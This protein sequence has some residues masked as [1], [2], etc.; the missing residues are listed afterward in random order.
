ML[1]KSRTLD[2]SWR[3]ISQWPNMLS[4]ARLLMTPVI[5]V[6]MLK[7]SWRL[8]FYCFVIACITDALDGF[9]ARLLHSKTVLGTILDPLA[10]KMLLLTLFIIM[11][12]MGQVSP[13]LF[14][15]VIARDLLIVIG[16][17]SLYWWRHN[18]IMEPLLIGKLTT[19]VQMLF[20]TYTLYGLAF[21]TSLKPIHHDVIALVVLGVTSISGVA[22]LISGV[23]NFSNRIS[24]QDITHRKM[25]GML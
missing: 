11:V 23:L 1:T 14:M 5:A 7:G 18:L 15:T 19:V 12:V 20:L 4:L 24:S 3:V 6:L 22:Y 21:P 9:M 16:A 13:A 2:V 25:R 8:S 10:D 17:M